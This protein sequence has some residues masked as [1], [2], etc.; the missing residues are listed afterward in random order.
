LDSPFV[1]LYQEDQ[2]IL[3]DLWDPAKT[4][5]GCMIK[6]ILFSFYA[7]Y[8]NIPPVRAYQDGSMSGKCS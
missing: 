3:V 5:K 8:M 6:A 4:Q 2:I 7:R 1:Q